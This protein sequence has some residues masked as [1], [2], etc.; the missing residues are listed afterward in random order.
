[1]GFHDSRLTVPLMG[2]DGTGKQLGMRKKKK[3][4]TSSFQRPFVQGNYESVIPTNDL[5]SFPESF[6]GFGGGVRGTETQI[7]P[8]L[9]FA[10]GSVAAAEYGRDLSK[11]RDRSMTEFRRE[12]R[13]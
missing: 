7:Q 11:P 10:S 5:G 4:S 3:M 13:T 2:Y 8:Y 12:Y 6:Q 1:M 9:R